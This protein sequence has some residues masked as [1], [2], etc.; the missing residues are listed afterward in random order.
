MVPP[1]DPSSILIDFKPTHQGIIVSIRTS[2][3][4]TDQL[5]EQ[6]QIADALFLTYMLVDKPRDEFHH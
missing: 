1:T 5:I 6:S 2:H 3:H 4:Y